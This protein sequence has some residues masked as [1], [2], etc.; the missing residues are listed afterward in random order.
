MFTLRGI[1]TGRNLAT[2]VR[3]LATRR[4]RSMAPPGKKKQLDVI[5]VS[6]LPGLGD[7]GD[8]ITLK[9]GFARNFLI[10]KKMAVYATPEN[11]EKHFVEKEK[12][13]EADTHLSALAYKFQ[14]R[15]LKFKRG[16]RNQ[17]KI[18]AEMLVES[19][20]KQMFLEIP[21]ARLHLP[22]PI[23]TVGEHRI[24]VLLSQDMATELRVVID[25]H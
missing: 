7:K 19:A 22:D 8:L 17:W 25:P 16:E 13:E 10:P 5:L 15:S 21:E 20:R 23:T 12:A 9:P 4:R 11:I 18:T 2:Q 24:P 1:R 14:K 3:F 6:S